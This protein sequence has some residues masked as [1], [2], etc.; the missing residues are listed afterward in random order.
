MPDKTPVT[1]ADIASIADVSIDAVNRVLTG[2][3]SIPQAEYERIVETFRDVDHLHIPAATRTAPSIGIP[4][5]FMSLIGDYIG[6]VMQGIS[7]GARELGVNLNMY[8]RPEGSTENLSADE[9]GIRYQHLFGETGND[10]LILIIPDVDTQLLHLCRTQQIPYVL[11]NHDPDEDDNNFNEVIVAI[12]NRTAIKEAMS[13]LIGLGHRRIG[14]ITGLM[15]TSDAKQRRQGY[16][17]ALEAADITFDPNL[18]G[19]GNWLEQSGYEA[20]LSLLKVPDVPTA[21]VASNDLMALGA[22]RAASEM[23]LRVGKDLS[24]IGFDDIAL[25]SEVSPSLT[26]IA[27]P[28][29]ELGNAAVKL[30][31]QLING[32]S[33]SSPHVLFEAKLVVRQSTSAPAMQRR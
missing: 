28:M 4:L 5:P 13:Y 1:D 20:A 15:Q 22:A 30:L 14:F 24:L 16:I 3:K 29:D 2:D 7:S 23:G 19:T 21:I 27:Q 25:A 33:P 17:E 18:V 8:T 31:A 32:V 11:M 26:T 12:D 9:L 10:G 6:E